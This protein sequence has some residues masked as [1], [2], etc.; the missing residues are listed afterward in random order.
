MSRRKS[1]DD[2]DVTVDELLPVDAATPDEPAKDAAPEKAKETP[3]EEANG[4]KMAVVTRW[5]RNPR[6]VMARLEGTETIVR[7]KVTNC[8]RFPRKMTIPIRHLAAGVWELTRRQPRSA[9]R[10]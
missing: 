3:P 1:K 9:G 6:L 8:R 7:V 10:W 5:V 2:V 4:E